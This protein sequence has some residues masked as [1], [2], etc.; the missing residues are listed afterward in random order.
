MPCILGTPRQP[1][2]RLGRHYTRLSPF[3]DRNRPQ[4]FLDRIALQS[5]I[6]VLSVRHN[7]SET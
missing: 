2:N 6:H 5:E 7:P 1:G 4:A 3:N